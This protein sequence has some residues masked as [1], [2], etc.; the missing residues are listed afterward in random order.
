MLCKNVAARQCQKKA[1]KNNYESVHFIDGA[2]LLPT[3]LL[4][5]NSF[6]GIF[7]IFGNV[8][9][10]IYIAEQASLALVL[11]VLRI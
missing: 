10:N 8:Y 6:T 7:Q 4:K 1:L 2:C 9:S 3:S 5:M 11:E